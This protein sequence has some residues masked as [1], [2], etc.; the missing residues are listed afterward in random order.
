MEPT[1]KTISGI[2]DELG[3]G[4][5]QVQ[6]VVLAGGVSWVDGTE[7]FLFGTLPKSVAE[8]A[9]VG[10][11]WRASLLSGALAGKMLGNYVSFLSDKYFAR[12][13]PILLSYAC[14]IFCAAASAFC[15]VYGLVVAFW[16]ASAFGLG[17]GLPIWSSLASEAS[18]S[19]NRMEIAGWSYMFFSVGSMCVLI[20]QYGYDRNLDFGS[21]WRELILWA[22]LPCLM[23]FVA[24]WTI[25]FA[26]SAHALAAQG[27]HEEARAELEAMR[28]RNGRPE[29]GVD[30][31]AHSPKEQLG[32]WEGSG[33]LFSKHRRFVTVTLCVLTFT[34]NFTSYGTLYAEGVVL[35]SLQLGVPTSVVLFANPVSDLLG[36]LAGI[37]LSKVASRRATMMTYQGMAVFYYVLFIVGLSRLA[38]SESDLLGSML[39][40]VV[41]MTFKFFMAIGW[42]S[43]YT[44]ATEVYPTLCR[45]FATGF[46]LG[47]GRLGSISAPLVLE[48]MH[49]AT[50]SHLSFFCLIVCLLVA[51][52][53]LV[54]AC[55]PETKD[56]PLEGF[57]GE[58]RP[59]R[60][61]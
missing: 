49:L 8:Q 33:A 39:V 61:A 52:L 5:A 48:H 55:L 34:L 13:L 3:L 11:Y 24:A 21:D 47:C 40:L 58:L 56:L 12:R 53:V 26:D 60:S 59:L 31:E 51:N 16:A 6:L 2:V 57:L 4:L 43:V 17:F 54:A 46:V 36:Q 30:F 27:R 14:S 29:V 22:Q 38:Q 23:L 10:P 19:T 37:G 20:I 9:N 18:P 35:P 7:M 42:L 25:G 28:R 50:E 41:A 15:D 45:S 44:Y 32:L 1:K